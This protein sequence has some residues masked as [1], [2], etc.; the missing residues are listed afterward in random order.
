MD[1]PLQESGYHFNPAPSNSRKTLQDMF[2]MEANFSTSAEGEGTIA[3]VAAALG[4]ID[5]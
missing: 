5:E 3:I 4:E 1:S 2:V